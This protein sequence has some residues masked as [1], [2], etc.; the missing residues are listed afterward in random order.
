VIT[1]GDLSRSVGLFNYNDFGFCQF[2]FIQERIQESEFSM[3]WS[4]MVTELVEVLANAAR[5]L[6]AS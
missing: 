2:S 3:N 1:K 5:S 6:L 4:L